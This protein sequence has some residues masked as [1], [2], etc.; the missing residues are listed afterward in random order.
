MSYTIL[1]HDGNTVRLVVESNANP[2][3]KYDPNR[4]SVTYGGSIF[5]YGSG[6]DGTSLQIM[7]LPSD[8]FSVVEGDPVTQQMID[9]DVKEQFR[10]LY[11]HELNA[12][13]ADL[14]RQIDQLKGT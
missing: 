6:F 10:W 7:I 9:A 5:G 2:D 11:T 4:K 14:Q 8:Q 12:K 3:I 13:L 1:L